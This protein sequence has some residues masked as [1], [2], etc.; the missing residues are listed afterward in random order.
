MTE[1]H[2]VVGYLAATLATLSFFLQVLKTYIERRTKDISLGMYVL[3]CSGVSLWLVYGL[4]I[5]SWPMIIANTATLIFSG[6]VLL[7]KIKHG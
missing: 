7:L 4:M 3:F 6:M 2:D 5:S 1:Y